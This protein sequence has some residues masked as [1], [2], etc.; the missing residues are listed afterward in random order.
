MQ[1]VYRAPDVIDGYR[2][3]DHLADGAYAAVYRAVPADGESP[4]VLK[5]PHP[6][7]LERQVLAARWRREATLTAQLDHPHIQRQ[8]RAGAP[9]SRPYL[10]LEYAA[11]GSLRSWLTD[12]GPVDWELALTWA[13]QLA[14]VLG[15]LHGLGIVHRDLKPDNVLLTDTLDVKL[16]DFG[17]AV[18]LTRR[19]LAVCLADPL[20]G[21]PDYLAPEQIKGEAGGIRSDLYS[22]GIMVHELLTGAA[23]FASADA[24]EI[25]AA[26]LQAEPP[27][28]RASRPDVPVG[29][30]AV[31]RRAMRR[32]PAERYPDAA[33]IVEDLRNLDRAALR[34]PDAGPQA[35]MGE[36]SLESLGS[37]ARLVAVVAGAFVAVV[38]VVLAL[39]VLLR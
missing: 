31:V 35:S 14:E 2:I 37:L 11:R 33:A 39:T 34:Q 15:Y 24:M 30:E 7:V 13:T 1:H 19:R 17:A 28:I 27:Q 6:F 16:G 22:W 32:W 29:L 25:M 8:L 4:V 38:S 23:P 20:E 5:F 21:T 12:R 9:R 3:V 10:V 36:P 18:R 26:H